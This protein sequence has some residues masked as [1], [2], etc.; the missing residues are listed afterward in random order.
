MDVNMLQA[1]KLLLEHADMTS[2]DYQL[3]L[4]QV[5]MTDL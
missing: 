5:R 1:V 2:A 4:T 3:G